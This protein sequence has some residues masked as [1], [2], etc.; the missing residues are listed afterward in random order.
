METYSASFEKAYEQIDDLNRNRVFSGGKAHA[1][2]VV[3]SYRF[4]LSNA[5][6]EETIFDLHKAIAW[7][8]MMGFSNP[9]ITHTIRISY[10]DIVDESKQDALIAFVRKSLG[11]PSATLV[12]Q[13]ERVETH[14]RAVPY[15][16][17]MNRADLDAVENAASII[18]GLP[19]KNCENST[20]SFNF[21]ICTGEIANLKV[22]NNNSGVPYAVFDLL[23]TRRNMS[24]KERN[25][26]LAQN[27]AAEAIRTSFK[28]GDTVLLVGQL[29]ERK[30]TKKDGSIGSTRELY[31]ESVYRI[32]ADNEENDLEETALPFD[33]KTNT[34]Q[35]NYQFE[36]I[37]EFLAY[38]ATE[39]KE[40]VSW[41]DAKDY[42]EAFKK[43]FEF[44]DHNDYKSAIIEYEKCLI[45]NPVAYKARLELAHCYTLIGDYH[46]AKEHL[47]EMTKYKMP[48]NIL[49]AYYRKYG[50]LLAE[51]GRNVASYACYKF[52]MNIENSNVAKEEI[53][54][55]LSITG[56]DLSKYD[57][58][59]VMRQEGIPILEGIPTV[60]GK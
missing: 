17:S 52:S 57:P 48:Y 7:R 4:L 12:H 45:V 20:P 22:G 9:R 50:F 53:D 10:A 2:N 29:S 54:Y 32:I 33:S 60:S 40:N 38:A 41:V 18:K 3:D 5:L 13:S 44:V 58:E 19:I 42:N 11:N 56:P 1:K 24:Q 59:K 43:G 49:A 46:K 6:D 16:N 36:R 23:T 27:T 55:L 30:W 8:V 51:Q 28:E 26:V 31:A 15:R 37:E 35:R 25:F 39:P 14:W 34:P 47:E 21:V